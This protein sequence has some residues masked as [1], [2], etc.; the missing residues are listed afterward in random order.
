[1]IKINDKIIKC[2]KFPNEETLIDTTELN[3]VENGCNIYF[4]FTTNESILHFYF[5][6]SHL[7]D[8]CIKNKKIFIYYMPYSRMDRTQNGNCFTLKYIIDIIQSK[9]APNDCIYI[10]EPHSFESLNFYNKAERINIIT[11]VMKQIVSE[12]KIDIICYPDKGAK[13]RFSDD[14]VKLPVIYC[15]KVRDFESGKILGLK[16]VTDV[17][18][19]DKNVLILDDLCSAGGTFYYTSLE[20]KKSGAK[21]V[22]LGVCHMEQNIINGKLLTEEKPIKHIYCFDTML[23]HF[24]KENF[25][26][27][28]IITIYNIEKFLK[29]GKVEE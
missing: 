4:K 6:L 23:D 22:F 15:E 29:N 14:V 19:K 25:S 12:Q 26:T 21:D 2:T 10:V 28:P 11:P 5:V 1:M 18:I 17:D 3:N 7:F 13:E 24:V 9:L 8:R 20:L 16:L 27:F